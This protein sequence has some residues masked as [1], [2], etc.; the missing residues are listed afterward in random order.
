MFERRNG[1][2]ILEKGIHWFDL[3]NAAQHIGMKVADM[4]TLALDGAVRWPPDW[5][6]EPGWIAELDLLERRKALL[7]AERA[8]AEKQ[9]A[10]K[11]RRPTDAQI[12]SWHR[13][14]IKLDSYA[15]IGTR[16]G[17]TGRPPSQHSLRLNV[18]I[19]PMP[20]RPELPGDIERRKRLTGEGD[21]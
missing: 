18:P 20:E 12:E 10:R 13:P 1:K 16:R 9:A 19:G 7:E 5:N 21:D 11:K 17:E 15:D 4:T 2:V 6:N 3:G 8:K 14:K